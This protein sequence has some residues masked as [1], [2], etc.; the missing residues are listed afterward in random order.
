MAPSDDGTCCRISP[1]RPPTADSRLQVPFYILCHVFR[2]GA[3][4]FLWCHNSFARIERRMENRQND[5]DFL[6]TVKL[7]SPFV[8]VCRRICRS[9]I[10]F[11]RPCPLSHHFPKWEIL[12]SCLKYLFVLFVVSCHAAES[13]TSEDTHVYAFM[14]NSIYVFVCVCMCA[15]HAVYLERSNSLLWW[16]IQ[17]TDIHDIPHT[18]RHRKAMKFFRR[19]L[20]HSSW[21]RKSF[22]YVGNNQIVFTDTHSTGPAQSTEAILASVSKVYAIRI[23][24]QRQDPPRFKYFSPHK[25]NILPTVI[26]AYSHDTVAHIRA[27]TKARNSF[28]RNTTRATKHDLCTNTL[29]IRWMPLLERRTSESKIHKYIKLHCKM[30]FIV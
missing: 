10:P 30:L 25:Q 9:C 11:D 22:M 18:I 23:Q 2:Q 27:F 17:N 28:G 26:S 12:F 16:P 5:L 20:Y 6:W 7:W 19:N 21:Y 14:H 4:K 13:F 1:P 24:A 3:R 29:Y 15:L 8:V